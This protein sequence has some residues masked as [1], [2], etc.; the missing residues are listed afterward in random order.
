MNYIE[1]IVSASRIIKYLATGQISLD[2]LAPQIMDPICLLTN[3][4]ERWWGLT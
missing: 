3:A 4:I 2:V 1:S